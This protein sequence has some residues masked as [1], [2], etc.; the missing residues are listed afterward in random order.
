M[1]FGFIIINIFLVMDKK[2]IRLTE[3]DFQRLIEESVKTILNEIQIP[4]N[5]DFLN[6]LDSIDNRSINAF[7]QSMIPSGNRVS[8]NSPYKGIRQLVLYFS[9]EGAVKHGGVIT[10]DIVNFIMKDDKIRKIVY[11]ISQED[12]KII[13]LIYGANKTSGRDLMQQ[14]IWHLDGITDQLMELN[15]LMN[16]ANFKNYFSGT[17]AMDG[18]NDGKRVGLS[19]IL[20]KAYT[21]ADEIK[22]QNKKMQE[23]LDK[24]KDAFSYRIR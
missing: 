14:I 8:K 15:G 2:L 12:K 23:I 3:S 5:K 19:N 6:G 9:P 10:K 11:A 13:D 17:D 1:L 7:I 20:F 18:S 24:P 16:N 4:Y 21:G 22:R